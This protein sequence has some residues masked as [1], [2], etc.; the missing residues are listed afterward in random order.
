MLASKLIVLSRFIIVV[1]MVNFSLWCHAAEADVMLA[2]KWKSDIDV[3]GWWL[4][5]KLDGV[6]GCWNGTE[7]KTRSGNSIRIPESFL[8]MFP[9]FPLDGEL[10]M[11]RGSFP[12][13]SGIVRKKNAADEWKKVKFY[14]F[15]V[16]IEGVPFED[17]IK[18]A[19]TW[20]AVHKS[21]FAIVLEQTKCRGREHLMTELV[22]IEKNNGEGIM[23]RRPG[24]FFSK[25]RSNDILKVKSFHDAEAVVV[26]HIT[27]KGRNRNRM[28]S[29]R[30][31]L[32]NG[33]Q[34]LIGSGFSDAQRENPP[35]VG[36]VVTFK[37]KEY[38]AAG[39]PRF[40]S[41]LRVRKAL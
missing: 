5:E 36:S 10:W 23:L 20:F 26:A 19:E 8:R 31:A 21:E 11:G 22:S 16:P 29:I 9:P 13:V 39:I 7:M 6:R 24:S 35:P 3:S 1:L 2:G 12:E 25:G 40:A 34:F 17:R 33:T 37:Y 32:P 15:D 30:V 38:T 27:G 41:F 4:S 18:K 28:G 14:I